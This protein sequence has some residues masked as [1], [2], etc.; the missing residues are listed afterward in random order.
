MFSYCQHSSVF[1]SCF[2]CCII[3][4]AL[5]RTLFTRMQMLQHVGVIPSSAGFASGASRW[6]KADSVT[7]ESTCFQT[8]DV[9]LFVCF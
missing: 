2:C 5:Y 9:L 8:I 4:P 1:L 3:S 7:V 6:P